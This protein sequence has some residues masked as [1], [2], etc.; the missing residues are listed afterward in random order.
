MVR[1]TARQQMHDFL[2]A[3]MAGAHKALEQQRQIAAATEH[4]AV[5]RRVIHAANAARI[6]DQIDNARHVHVFFGDMDR[7]IDAIVEP[8]I[9]HRIHRMLAG[10]LD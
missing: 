3:H 5:R 7:G 10:A 9:G 8:P 2:D 6:A 1:Q 4:L